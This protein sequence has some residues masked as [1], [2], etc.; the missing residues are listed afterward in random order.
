MDDKSWAFFC[1][2]A[3]LSVLGFWAGMSDQYGVAGSCAG[4]ALLAGLVTWAM[5]T[6]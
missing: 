6:Y 4:G 3:L 2:T 1:L 5:T